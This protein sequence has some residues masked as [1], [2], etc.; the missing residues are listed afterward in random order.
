[1]CAALDVLGLRSYH[2]NEVLSHKNNGHL[3]LWLKALQAKFDGLGE[4]LEGND[5]DRMLWDYDSVSDEPCCHFVEELI[6]AYPS[7]KVVLTTRT[8]ESWLRSY[9][10]SILE[11]LSWRK[12]C[13]LL[14]YFDRDFIAPWWALLNRSTLIL[15]QGMPAYQ[16][17]AHP[18]L[19]ESFER[20]TDHVRRVVPSQ[21]LLEFNPSQGWEPLCAFLEVPVPE[22]E[23]PHLNEPKSLVKIR[24]DM[25][26]ERWA[27]VIREGAK[28]WTLLALA[29][30]AG[31][32]LASG[33][34]VGKTAS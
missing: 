2:W 23:F 20:H 1:M 21:R 19:L 25:Y 28:R 27:L 26:W 5:F 18:A 6:A 24:K 30:V 29:L 12:S 11:V 8:P 32:W 16:A 3:Q 31:L 10:N 14:S 13:A 17:T 34:A 22:V 4:P 9:Q 33:A 15:S 7:A